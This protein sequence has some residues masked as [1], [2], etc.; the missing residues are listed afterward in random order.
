M[1]KEIEVLALTPKLSASW[2]ENYAYVGQRPFRPWWAKH[3][4]GQMR[5][6]KFAAKTTIH[7]AHNGQSVYLVDGQH[8]L[9][10]L[11]LGGIGSIKFVV[12]HHYLEGTEDELAKLYSRLDQGLKRSFSDIADAWGLIQ[13]TQVENKT[14]L[15]QLNA[16]CNAMVMHWGVTKEARAHKIDLET[17]VANALEW[18]PYAIPFFESVHRGELG[19][20]VLKSA[21]MAI[22]IITF[23]H[24]PEL[25]KSFWYQVSFNDRLARYDPRARLHRWLLDARISRVRGRSQITY[26]N[27]EFALACGRCWNAYIDKQELQKLYIPTIPPEGYLIKL[28]DTRI[29]G[30]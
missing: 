22:A 18:A 23:R 14:Q 12:T 13:A 15:N 1:S 30:K 9:K 21:V 17:S 7:L 19:S 28:T 6:G 24:E 3:L 11:E 10:A 16:A 29:G 8:R 5:Q 27:I 20:L 4:N 26:S 2:L 25:A